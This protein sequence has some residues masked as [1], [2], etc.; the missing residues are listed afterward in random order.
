MQQSL[1][2]PIVFLMALQFINW[3]GL[4]GWAALFN[5]FGKEAAGFGGYQVGIVQSVREIPGFLAFTA[6]AWFLIMREQIFGVFAL[7]ILGFG[8]LISGMFPTLGGVLM[9]TLVMSTGFH[10]A[11]TV[12]QSLA[13]QIF[14]KAQA[15]QL[16]GKVASAGAVASMAG[17]GGMALM[18][19]A[20][21][22]DYNVLFAILGSVCILLAI[23]AYFWFPRIEGTVPQRKTIV[24]RPRYWLYY[25]LT[26]M[27][28]ARRQ[29]FM[30]FAGFLLVERFGFKVLDVA[31][32]MLATAALTT[33]CAPIFG[34]IIGQ[35]GER[36]T[37]M[38]E[39]VGL[40]IVFAGYATTNDGRVAALLFVLD[41]LFMILLI[42][43]R[44]YFQKIGDAADMSPTAAVAFTINHIAAVFIP[45]GFGIL[46]IKNPALVFQAGGLIASLSLIL[47]FLVPRDPGPGQETVFK[48][49]SGKNVGAL[50][51]G[52]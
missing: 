40:I 3:L 29:I 26:F 24:L 18:W 15:A 27:S 30:A 35:I 49:Q 11:E 33:L 25:A 37:I 36:R 28:G 13:L 16:L 41:G 12:T 42:A 34:R 9:T 22:H 44:T 17:Y 38:V 10:Y 48:E 6:I 51:P 47:S 45:F 19:W 20:G 7:I 39:N 50:Q 4:A 1:R 5:N 2:S 8:C 32:L 23:A 43:Q 21:L 31:L 52:R 46:W 14:P